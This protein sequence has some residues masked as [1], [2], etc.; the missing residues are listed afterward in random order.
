MYS[1]TTIYEAPTGF[2]EQAPYPLALVKLE[3]GP[4]LTAQLTDLDPTK[5]IQIH[6]KV[7]MVTRR[8]KIDGDPDRGLIVYGPKFRPPLKRQMPSSG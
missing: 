6:D 1:H 2:D 8:L 7:E 3:E 5:P 4:L